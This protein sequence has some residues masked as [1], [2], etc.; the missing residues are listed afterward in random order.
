PAMGG[1][2]FVQ[3]ENTHEHHKDNK[4]VRQ[5][6][7]GLS[8]AAIIEIDHGEHGHEANSEP[9]KLPEQEMIAIAVLLARREC[10]GAKYHYGSGQ[11]E[12]D[13]GKEQPSICF[14]S[15]QHRLAF[16]PAR[17]LNTRAFPKRVYPLF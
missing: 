10:R 4:E 16:A 14:G 11:A 8:Q 1:V 9:E 6:Q 12:R 5:D 15:S 13:R 2:R 17:M 3:K 7:L